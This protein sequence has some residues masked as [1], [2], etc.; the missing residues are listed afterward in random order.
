MSTIGT[1]IQQSV[2]IL[3]QSVDQGMP[4]QMRMLSLQMYQ[5]QLHQHQMHQYQMH[6]QQM[7]QIQI[8]YQ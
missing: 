5:D 3:G 7:H 1:A 4:N 6:Q 2:S 8:T